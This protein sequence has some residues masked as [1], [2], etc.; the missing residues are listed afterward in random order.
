MLRY[1]LEMC[2][3]SLYFLDQSLHVREASS[4]LLLFTGQALWKDCF[5]I[6]Q[7]RSLEKVRYVL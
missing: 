4:V 1:C 2:L 3:L 5:C 6:Y 7:A